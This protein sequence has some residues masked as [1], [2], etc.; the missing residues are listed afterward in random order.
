MVRG[1]AQRDH[2]RGIQPADP[3]AD[4]ILIASGC[5]ASRPHGLRTNGPALRIGHR[6]VR[7]KRLVTYGGVPRSP[8][9]LAKAMARGVARRG[10]ESKATCVHA[11]EQRWA[12]GGRAGRRRPGYLAV[13]DRT[14]PPFPRLHRFRNLPRIALGEPIVF[15]RKLAPPIRLRSKRVAQPGPGS[16]RAAK[17]RQRA[18]SSLDKALPPS[19]AA[20]WPTKRRRLRTFA[21]RRRARGRN[22]Q[23]AASGAG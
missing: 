1:T 9:S 12:R 4:R 2:E 23:L 15:P 16:A 5:P 22:A 19:I 6:D 3:G 18:A 7:L 13:S 14:G 17:K 10:G 20:A 11:P 8:T 21:L